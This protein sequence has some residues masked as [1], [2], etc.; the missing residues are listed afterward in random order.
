[1]GEKRSVYRLF[2]GK[3]ERKQQVNSPY[4]CGIEPSGS[5]KCWETFKWP[6]N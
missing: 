5:T 2:V 4:E 1:M 6:H 3:P